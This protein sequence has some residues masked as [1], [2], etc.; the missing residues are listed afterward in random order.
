MPRIAPAHPRDAEA[1]R[2][3]LAASGLPVEDMDE[4]PVAWLVAVDAGRVV[5]VA[6][7]EAHG[8]AGLLRSLAV[9]PTHRGTGLGRALARAVE[10]D[11]R[12]RGLRQLVLLTVTAR[13]F[14]ASDGYLQIARA[15]AP[16]AIRNT[17][18]FRSLCPAT[19]T[20]MAKAL[21]PEPH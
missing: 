11:A 20:C 13:D 21:V 3:L 7:L 19:A 17:T 16:A 8:D 14:F 10:E 1:I 5:G 15:A 4:N 12:R 6:G 9:L 2:A 18:E